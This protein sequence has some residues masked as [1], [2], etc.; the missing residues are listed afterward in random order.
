MVEKV[1]KNL[2]N[3]NICIRN[4]AATT[5]NWNKMER[6]KEQLF[7]FADNKNSCCLENLLKS[8]I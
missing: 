2:K 6:S 5:L 3:T 1:N 4:K 7:F 8:F